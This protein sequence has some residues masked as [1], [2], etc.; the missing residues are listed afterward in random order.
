MCI[1]QFWI[2]KTGY[3]LIAVDKLLY[4]FHPTKKA[5]IHISYNSIDPPFCHRITFTI[6]H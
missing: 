6:L 4:N 2:A 3:N 1:V 5:S